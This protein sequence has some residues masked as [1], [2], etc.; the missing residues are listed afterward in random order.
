MQPRWSA[1]AG[2]TFVHSPAETRARVHET[3]AFVRGWASPED[4]PPPPQRTSS[5]IHPR[6]CMSPDLSPRPARVSPH[7]STA[8]PT[9]R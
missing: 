9:Y 1:A 4:E 6:N 5:P 8:V 3:A 7:A 2:C